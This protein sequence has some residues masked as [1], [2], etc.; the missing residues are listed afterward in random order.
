M[1]ER[2]LKYF[3]IAKARGEIHPCETDNRTGHRTV[4]SCEPALISIERILLRII[5]QVT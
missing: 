2:V 4:T 5:G 3:S 1:S